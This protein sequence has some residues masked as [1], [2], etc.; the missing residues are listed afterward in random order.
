M[1]FF[2]RPMLRG[3]HFHNPVMSDDM[4]RKV[5]PSIFATEAHDS[6]SARYTYIPTVDILNGLRREGFQ[7][8]AAM[9]SRARDESK[10]DHTKHLI[11]LRHESTTARAVG[12]KVSFSHAARIDWQPGDRFTVTGRIVQQPNGPD[13]I[14]ALTVEIDR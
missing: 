6:R 11:R 12:L 13:Y 14:R 2:T 3:A 9:Q 1:T 4:L 5:A 7:P 10:R 8:V